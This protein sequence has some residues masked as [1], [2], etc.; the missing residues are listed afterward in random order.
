MWFRP[1]SLLNF[2]KNDYD[3]YSD[4]QGTNLN[5]IFT[6]MAKHGGILKA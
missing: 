3:N 2:L 5:K 4:P 6:K 1:A